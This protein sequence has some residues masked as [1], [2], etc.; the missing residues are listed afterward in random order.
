MLEMLAFILLVC[1][2]VIC[3][4]AADNASSPSAIC[5]Y[6]ES[7]SCFGGN[8]TLSRISP[9]VQVN[10]NTFLELDLLTSN[11]SCIPLTDSESALELDLEQIEHGGGEC[12][13]LRA[14]FINST[15]FTS[16]CA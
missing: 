12:N 8:Q 13:C 16:I 15:N 9:K 6:L 2:L 1:E 5:F 7:E 11:G 10:D 4:G 3:G 14:Y